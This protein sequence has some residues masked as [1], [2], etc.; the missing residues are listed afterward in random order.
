MTMHFQ[1]NQE[2]YFKAVF[3]Q[4]NPCVI[5]AKLNIQ[6]TDGRSEKKKR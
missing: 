2:I 6:K 5:E 3:G 4:E 1:I